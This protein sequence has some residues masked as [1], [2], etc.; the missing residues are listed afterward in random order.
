[1]GRF[2]GDLKARVAAFMDRAVDVAMMMPRDRRLDRV[3]D[4]LMGASTSV[5]ANLAEA[6][7]AMSARGFCKSLA[8]VLKELNETRFWFE[9]IGRKNWIANS[10]LAPVLTEA[11]EMK[12]IIGTIIRNTRRSE[13]ACGASA[14]VRRS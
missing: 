6:D 2:R 8:I 4:Q 9:L 12:R 10:R 7:E 1:M 5:G 11:D 14:G 3:V 13:R